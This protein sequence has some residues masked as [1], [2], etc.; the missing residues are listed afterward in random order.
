M[1]IKNSQQENPYPIAHTAP[2]AP[3]PKILNDIK[4]PSAVRKQHTGNHTGFFSQ[5]HVSG[6][7]NISYA[8]VINGG[9]RIK[10]RP[11]N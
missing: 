9:N 8:M 6:W 7:P 11:E 3:N 2:S 4:P 5:G 10:R 1:H